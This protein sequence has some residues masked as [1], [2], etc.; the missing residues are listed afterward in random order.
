[1]PLAMG[2]VLGGGSSINAMAWARGHKN[3]WDFF[4]SEVGD[5]AWNYQSVL[6]IYRR[7]EDWHG[8]PDPDYRG[9]GGPVFVQPA[10]DP[11]P[12]A[13]AMVEAARLVGI[14]TFS[15]HN[16]RRWRPAAV[17]L[18]WTCG[19]ARASDCQSSAPTRTHTGPPEFDGPDSCARHAG[20]L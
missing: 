18:L 1:M 13:P 9:T 6:T 20:D 5:D 8:E 12:I 11:N 2:K 16:G 10:P 4:A 7:V 3:D 17:L 14:P 19:C 15:S